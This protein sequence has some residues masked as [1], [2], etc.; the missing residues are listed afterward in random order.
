MPS[1]NASQVFWGSELEWRLNT[2]HHLRDKMSNCWSSHNVAVKLV[3]VNG[4]AAVCRFNL[5]NWPFHEF[6]ADFVAIPIFHLSSNIILR[7]VSQLICARRS[8]TIRREIPWEL[9]Y[10]PARSAAYYGPPTWFL[11]F[12]L[13]L[14]FLFFGFFWTTELTEDILYRVAIM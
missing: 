3:V 14:S 9:E 8:P 2:D 10:E 13:S 6:H 11:L 1:Y 4:S 12:S 7:N 5:Q